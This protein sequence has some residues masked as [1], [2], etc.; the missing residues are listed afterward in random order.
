MKA[1][2]ES[3]LLFLLRPDNIMPLLVRIL[4]SSK[5]IFLRYMARLIGKMIPLSGVVTRITL[6]KATSK[7]G[8]PYALYNFEAVSILDPEEA[9]Q[10]RAFGQQF[11]DL[12]DAASLETDIAEV[13]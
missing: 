2:K 4:V 5:L 6:D 1:C 9:V 10:A 12:V 11:M 7:A 3:V 13:D 8:K